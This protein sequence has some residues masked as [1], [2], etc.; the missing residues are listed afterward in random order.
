MASAASERMRKKKGG[1]A[2]KRVRGDAEAVK[3]GEGRGK[4]DDSAF[5]YIPDLLPGKNPQHRSDSAGRSLGRETG[6]RPMDDFLKLPN[7]LTTVS[8]RRIRL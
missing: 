1:K 5:R 7:Q 3:A 4:D 6:I 2:G 8:I